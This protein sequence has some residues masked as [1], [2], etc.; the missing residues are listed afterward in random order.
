MQSSKALHVIN[1]KIKLFIALKLKEATKPIYC[2]NGVDLRLWL[3]VDVPKSFIITCFSTV[4][5]G[6]NLKSQYIRGICNSS[7]LCIYQIRR[8][9][10]QM[11][12]RP[13]KI[14][15]G[16]SWNK[17][18]GASPYYF[19]WLALDHEEYS[20]SM[21]LL[22]LLSYS[23][24]LIDMSY[25][26]WVVKIHSGFLVYSTTPL[27]HILRVSGLRTV[28]QFPPVLV[29]HWSHPI[30]WSLWTLPFYLLLLSSFLVTCWLLLPGSAL[31]EAVCQVW[32]C[33]AICSPVPGICRDAGAAL[34]AWRMVR[35]PMWG[36]SPVKSSPRP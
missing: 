5:C 34:M 10:I 21:F 12:L 35:K 25:T 18:K 26:Q 19:H 11:L 20:F 14:L 7:C 33:C 32:I 16:G 22:L 23:Y 9:N 6:T 28:S 17:R 30:F 27:K 3:T 24:N 15:M 31:P 4:M 2:T 8:I 1:S 13:K 29:L 36:V